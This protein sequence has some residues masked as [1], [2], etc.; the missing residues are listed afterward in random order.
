MSCGF[1]DA[2]LG[3]PSTHKYV[4]PHT[5]RQE[6]APP[7]ELHEGTK[8]LS[9]RELVTRPRTGPSYFPGRR[10]L[11]IFL[12]SSYGAAPSHLCIV[13]VESLVLTRESTR[14]PTRSC[15][16]AP[17]CHPRL[18]TRTNQEPYSHSSG[19][20]YPW[21]WHTYQHGFMM[22]KWIEQELILG[23]ASPLL[24]V[25][26]SLSTSHRKTKEKKTGVMDRRTD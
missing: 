16:P 5:I 20:K 17:P 1:V 23:F 3:I 15:V 14:P 21:W 26:F 13:T 19:Y 18:P 7:L 6:G 11:A 2:T 4:T 22:D 8:D 12:F 9:P 24:F 25:W 10:F